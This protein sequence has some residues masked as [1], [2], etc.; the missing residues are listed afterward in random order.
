MLSFSISEALDE[1][2]F[3]ISTPTYF[4]HL[5][6]TVIEVGMLSFVPSQL[7]LFLLP[8]LLV[9]DKVKQESHLP[10][11]ELPHPKYVLV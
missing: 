10:V 3:S 2:R 9:G 11:E 6:A 5:W 4:S 1:G 8:Y 7:P